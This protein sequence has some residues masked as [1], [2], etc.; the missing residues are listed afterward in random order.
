MPEWPLRAVG[1]CKLLVL[2]TLSS[3]RD[4]HPSRLHRGVRG[5]PFLDAFHLLLWEVAPGKSQRLGMGVWAEPGAQRSK[6]A[7][8][9]FSSTIMVAAMPGFYPAHLGAVSGHPERLPCCFYIFRRCWAPWASPRPVLG[10]SGLRHPEPH[11][12]GK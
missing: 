6:R 3:V 7:C 12:P 1:L 10:R 8:F 2:L 11:P 4:A 9:G 5:S